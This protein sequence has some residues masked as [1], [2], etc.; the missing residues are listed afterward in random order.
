MDYQI[1][2]IDSHPGKFPPA[3][4]MRKCGVPVTIIARW[5]KVRREMTAGL[6]RRV[7]EAVN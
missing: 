7:K 1:V 3:A 5:K 4:D 2:V 6:K